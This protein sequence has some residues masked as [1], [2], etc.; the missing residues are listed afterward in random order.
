V[1]GDLRACL[2]AALQRLGRVLGVEVIDF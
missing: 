1:R 2:D